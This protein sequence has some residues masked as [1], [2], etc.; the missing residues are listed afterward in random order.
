MS[1]VCLKPESMLLA[2][3]MMSAGGCAFWRWAAIKAGR[4]RGG[5][6]K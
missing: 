4:A 6:P 5:F 3:V 2:G 1:A